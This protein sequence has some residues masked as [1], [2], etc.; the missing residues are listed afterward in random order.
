MILT[1]VSCC[2]ALTDAL[3]AALV[4]RG[5]TLMVVCPAHIRRTDQP[6]S[7]KAEKLHREKWPTK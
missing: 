3:D 6:W 5:R 7:P 2:N 1:K 4:L